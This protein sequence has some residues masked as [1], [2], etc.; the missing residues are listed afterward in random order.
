MQTSRLPGPG[1]ESGAHPQP[2]PQGGIWCRPHRRA[3]SGLGAPFPSV[4]GSL[5]CAAVL[6]Q[7]QPLLQQLRWEQLGKGLPGRTEQ[8]L[9]APIV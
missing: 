8:V 7:H 6:G 5:G 3:D 9:P 1:D 4:T 2:P